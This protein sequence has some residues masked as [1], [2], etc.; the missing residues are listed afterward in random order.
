MLKQ[1]RLVGKS[2]IIRT[3][4]FHPLEFNSQW[5]CRWCDDSLYGL[6]GNGFNDKVK[7]RFSP[8][9]KYCTE[10]ARME[11][12]EPKGGPGSKMCSRCTMDR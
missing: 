9:G 2:T 8:D 6:F 7:V 11:P 3:R 10:I 5:G 12:I 4:L 1:A